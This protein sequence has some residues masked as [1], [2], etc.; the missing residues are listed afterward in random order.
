MKTMRMNMLLVVILILSMILIVS[1]GGVAKAKADVRVQ[2][3]LRTPAVRV[4]VDSSPRYHT[5]RRVVRRTPVTMQ[6]REIVRLT[7]QDRRI[8]KRL[9]W[10]TDVPKRELISLR[11]RGYEWMEIGMWLELPRSVVHAAYDQHS[12]KRFLRHDG[13]QVCQSPARYTNR[14][15]YYIDDGCPR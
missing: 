14:G 9:A 5:E 8:A 6:R 11:K 2:A 15:T 12:W 4:S 3:T 1:V 10:Y 13:R 7:K